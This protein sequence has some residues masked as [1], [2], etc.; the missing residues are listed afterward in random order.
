MTSRDGGAPRDRRTPPPS[1]P[2]VRRNM[3]ANRSESDVERRL[4]S[5]LHR[6][7]LRFRKNTTAVPGLRAR[8]DIVFS[9]ARIAVFVDGCFWH[10]CPVHATAPRANAR[11]WDAKLD[12]NVR[13]DRRSDRALREAGWTVLRVWEHEQLSNMVALVRIV[14]AGAEVPPRKDGN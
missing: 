2:A 11:W 9:R 6:E 14:L 10:R 13:R 4:R 8:P 5:A 1:S 7:G 3:R 12:E